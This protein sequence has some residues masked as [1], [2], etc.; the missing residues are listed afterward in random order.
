MVGEIVLKVMG[1]PGMT[2]MVPIVKRVGS[3]LDT[4]TMVTFAGSKP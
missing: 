2:V 3:P 1:P 4:A